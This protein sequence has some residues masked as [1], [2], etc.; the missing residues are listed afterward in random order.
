MRKWQ[1]RK[2][3]NNSSDKKPPTHPE[4]LY[5]WELSSVGGN[6]VALSNF[7][8]S[9]VMLLKKHFDVVHTSDLVDIIFE[10]PNEYKDPSSA[11]DFLLRVL[12]NRGIYEKSHAAY[13]DLYEKAARSLAKMECPDFSDMNNHWVFRAFQSVFES[14]S[15]D[16]VWFESF[17][18]RVLAYS[19]G[20][21]EI[22]DADIE[23]FSFRIKG[24][25]AYLKLTDGEQEIKFNFGPYCPPF[26]F[27]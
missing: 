20:R 24:P 14:F 11:L 1:I 8:F 19:E 21:V 18:K 15:L 5:C 12:K 26:Q 10:A 23:D 3:K 4:A 27:C 6:G 22:M 2:I 7:L 25:A 17:K 13:E 16:Q 9:D